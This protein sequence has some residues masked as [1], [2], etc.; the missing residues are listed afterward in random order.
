M[1]VPSSGLDAGD[2]VKVVVTVKHMGDLASRHT[3]AFRVLLL[4]SYPTK[5]LQLNTS[6]L[7]LDFAE[8]NSIPN[9]SIEYDTLAGLITYN[10]SQLAKSNLVDATMEFRL[11]DEVYSTQT[12]A[13]GLQLFWHTLPYE[14]NGGRNYSLS[15][16]QNVL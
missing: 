9:H 11:L 2:V 7:A 6:S 4:V 15:G 13:L 8:P 16:T 10:A 3:D 12:I 14:I 1:S 5:Y